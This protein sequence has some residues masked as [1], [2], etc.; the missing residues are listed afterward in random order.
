VRVAASW[1]RLFAFLV[2]FTLLAATALPLTILV[3][4]LLGVGPLTD[5]Q[6]IDALLQ[7]LAG[8]LGRALSRAVPL[9][10]LGALYFMLFAVLGG[11]TPG[12]R[13]L[14]IR[15]VAYHGESPSLSAALV[16]VIAGFVGMIPLGLGW[17]WM[18]FDMETRAWHDHL[19]RTYVVRNG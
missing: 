12:Q 17:L 19:A 16:R 6:G 10:L 13:L 3:Y 8:D 7:I 1:R 4:S 5:G 15:L 14:Q 18:L 2:D 9:L 11:Q